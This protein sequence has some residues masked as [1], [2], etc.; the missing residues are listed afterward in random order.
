MAFGGV[1]YTA[2][3]STGCAQGKTME[4]ASPSIRK[5]GVAK[6]APFIVGVRR[7]LIHGLAT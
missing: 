2:L 4:Q 5:S 6:A 3:G 7:R 1:Y